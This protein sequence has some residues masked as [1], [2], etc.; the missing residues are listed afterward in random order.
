MYKILNMKYLLLILFVSTTLLTKAQCFTNRH[1]T[2]W[3]DGWISCETAENPNPQRSNSHWLLYDFGEPY[4][5]AESHLWNV[6]DPVNLNAGIKDYTIDY[7]LDKIVWSTLGTFQ[8]EKASGSTFYEG[9]QGPEFNN[10]KA[11]YILL[12]AVSNYGA[13]CFGL[14]EIKINVGNESAVDDQIA[15]FDVLVYPNPFINDFTVKVNTLFAGEKIRYTIS[16]MAGRILYSGEWDKVLTENRFGF[17]NT[18]LQLKPGVYVIGITQRN[19]SQ[20]FKLVKQ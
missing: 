18:Q 4:T 11:R 19:Y 13:D 15:G 3:Y 12:T 17:S 7:S 5:L 2:S 8:L 16:D 9:T 10:L 14:S 20:T 1:S 6:N